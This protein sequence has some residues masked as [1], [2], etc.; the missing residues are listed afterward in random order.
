MADTALILIVDDNLPLQQATVR[1]LEQ[2]G[3]NTLAAR[4][5]QTALNLAR[6]EKPDLILLD[7]ELPDISG[8]EVCRLLKTDRALS[9]CLIVFCPAHVVD[10]HGGCPLETFGHTCTHSHSASLRGLRACSAV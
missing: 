8:A 5:G 10:R 9:S 6:A 7:M 1:L 4:D 3:Y 2:A